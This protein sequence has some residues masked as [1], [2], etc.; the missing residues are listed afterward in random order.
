MQQCCCVGGL[1]PAQGY[2]VFSTPCPALLFVSC[3]YYIMLCRKIQGL[4]R[5]ISHEIRAAVGRPCVFL[6]Y[7]VWN[8]E[9]PSHLL[10]KCQPP[11]TRGPLERKRTSQRQKAP[12][13]KGGRAA[14]RSPVAGGFYMTNPRVVLCRG[15]QRPPLRFSGVSCLE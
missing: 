15:G 8:R 5:I 12:L 4:F 14:G 3:F 9:S 1:A 2:G 11:L 7:H 6:E 10:R 13:A